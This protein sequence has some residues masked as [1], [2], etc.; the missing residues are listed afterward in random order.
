MVF[1]IYQHELAT[2]IRVL[3]IGT[4]LPHPS[5]PDPSGL[6]QSTSLLC[7]ASCIKLALV[8]YFTPSNEHVSMLFSQTISPS[9]SPTQSKSLFS[10]S[11]FPLHPECNIISTV[12]LNPISIH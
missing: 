11:V 12:F 9:P 7:P 8:I 6:S 10:M 4:P 2:G 5:S 1:A 3:P